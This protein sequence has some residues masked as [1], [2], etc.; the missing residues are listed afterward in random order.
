MLSNS[1]ESAI[2]DLTMEFDTI[3]TFPKYVHPYISFLSNLAA[4]AAYSTA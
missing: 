2:Y 3:N 4:A 1:H